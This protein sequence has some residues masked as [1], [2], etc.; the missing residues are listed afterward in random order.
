MRNI[1]VILLSLLNGLYL[2]GQEYKVPMSSGLVS[3]IGV[4]EIVVEGYDGTE[5]ILTAPIEKNKKIKKRKAC[6]SLVAMD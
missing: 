3:I 2:Y 1:C 6:A 5:V 4:D